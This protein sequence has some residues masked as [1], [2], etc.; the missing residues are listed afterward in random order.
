MQF[1]PDPRGS[2][3]LPP[4]TLWTL[5]WAPKFT[6]S[7][8]EIAPVLAVC[9]K[10]RARALQNAKKRTF[11][12]PRVPQGPKMEPKWSHIGAQKVFKI[13]VSK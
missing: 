12:G 5:P 10:V 7:S 1:Y 13:E 2:G 8:L 11:G 4:A 3:P 9:A 6:E